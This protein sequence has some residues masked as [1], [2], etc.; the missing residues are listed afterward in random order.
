MTGMAL[1][2]RRLAIGD[3]ALLLC[4]PCSARAWGP[5]GH[6]IIA[7]LAESHLTPA[8]RE[9][10]TQILQGVRMRDVAY[11]AD[12]VRPS[13]RETARWHFVNIELGAT[14][15]RPERDC[16][17][18]EGEGDCIIAAIA[19]N[20][21]DLEATGERQALALKFLIH[22]VADLHQPFHAVSEARGGN[23]I[24]V[25]FFGNA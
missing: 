3:F 21:E 12:L 22:F 8:A 2:L 24:R 20:I 4:I 18:L 17:Q 11:W 6:Q 23:Q 15:Y 1:K 19:R 9:R 14:D 5:E 13:R 7:D 25:T 10:V 16:R